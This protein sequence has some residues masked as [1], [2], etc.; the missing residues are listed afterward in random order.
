MVDKFDNVFLNV[1]QFYMAAVMTSPMI[2]IEVLIM[3]GMYQDKNLSA[4]IAVVSLVALA[5]FFFAVRKQTGVTDRQFLKSMIPHHSGAILMCEQSD[6]ADPEIRKLCEEII[7]N[8]E[9]EIKEMKDKLNALD[10]K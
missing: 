1:N 10:N 7:A 3:R 2:L 8:Q 6:I 4:I 5:G 9:K